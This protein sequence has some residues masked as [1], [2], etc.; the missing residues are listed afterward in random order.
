MATKLIRGRDR[1]QQS[2][3]SKDGTHEINSPSGQAKLLQLAPS[4]ASHKLALQSTK[5]ISAAA[6]DVGLVVLGISDP[7]KHLVREDIPA[8][9]CN[10]SLDF[11]NY[12]K[13]KKHCAVFIS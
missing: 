2:R 9:G 8:Q 7:G 6:F 4:F 10:F 11:G 12:A 3:I 5:G 13:R 1:G